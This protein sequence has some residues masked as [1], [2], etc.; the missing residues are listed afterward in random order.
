M[1]SIFKRSAIGLAV[2]GLAGSSFANISHAN[3]TMWSPG[4]TGW[5]IGVEGLDM[6]PQN[7]DLD[8]VTIVPG[9]TNGTFETKAISTSYDWSWRVYGGIN[10]TD[11][12]DLTFSWYHMNTSDH[13]SITPVTG[14]AGNYFA[15]WIFNNGG[16][17]WINGIGAKVKFDIDEAY[18]VWGHTINFNNP[19]SIRFAGGVEY[20][21]I[22]SDMSVSGVSTTDDLILGY[23]ADSHTQGWGPR[24]EFDATY[25]F[26]NYLFWFGNTNA[27]L[28]S[29]T[30]KISLNALDN[31]FTDGPNTFSSAFTTR[32]IVIPKLGMRLG[33]GYSFLFGQAGAE[34][35]CVTALTLEAGWQADAYI[36]AIERPLDGYISG[37]P[38]PPTIT[39]M[40][41]TKVSN[42]TDQGWF[43]GLKVSSNWI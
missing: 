3:N 10:F 8:Y 34:G 38:T 23:Q 12:D 43:I 25:H 33:L 21:K 17:G 35:G 39:S 7:G 42:F 26:T 41:D 1:K 29:S 30:R 11:N 18:L 5:F 2:L 4:L 9:L 27:A 31:D 40:A 28:L 22:D 16:T 15:R 24:I 19:W 36:H 20:A 32:H 6:R 14:F 37:S 13:D